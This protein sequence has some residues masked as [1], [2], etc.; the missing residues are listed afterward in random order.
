MTAKVRLAVLAFLAALIL[1]RPAL[2]ASGDANLAWAELASAHADLHYGSLAGD[3]QPRI[4][5][6]LEARLPAPAGRPQPPRQ[7][8]A[9]SARAVPAAVL[10]LVPRRANPQ[11]SDLEPG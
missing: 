10:P 2:P 11:P 5:A 1:G 3:V 9:A 7:I 8:R 6:P 4:A